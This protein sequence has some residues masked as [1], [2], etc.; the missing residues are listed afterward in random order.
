ME[1]KT[2]YDVSEI[3]WEIYE[4]LYKD[5]FRC[6]SKKKGERTYLKQGFEYNGKEIS[7]A[8]FSGETDFNF[9]IGFS[10]SRL[11]AYYNFLKHSKMPEEYKK[12]YTNQLEI[13]RQLTYCIL[14]ISV[15][16][17]S[18]NL[19]STKGKLA[20]DRIDTY[21]YAIDCYYEKENNLLMNYSSYENLE[22]LKEYLGLFESAHEYCRVIYHIS[23]SL[24]DDLIE[25][26]KKSIDTPEEL[27]NYM[28]LAYRFWR[29]KLMYLNSI[30]K[31]SDTIK[32]ELERLSKILDE[33][34]IV[35]KDN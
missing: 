6:F 12:M 35:D 17:Q 11:T 18:G 31:L 3:A 7:T 9:K 2:E 4:I 15:L 8:S 24:V 20:N 26:G 14:N 1:E 32:K 28:K 33:W 5:N 23:E 10:H 34:F 25:S 13:C 21:I 16:P 27:I 29:Q 30:D 19:Q 22:F